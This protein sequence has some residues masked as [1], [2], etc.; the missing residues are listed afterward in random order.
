MNRETLMGI[1]RKILTPDYVPAFVPASIL[2]YFMGGSVGGFVGAYLG[3][4]YDRAVPRRVSPDSRKLVE[5]S[6]IISSD[7]TRRKAAL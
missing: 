1:G 3:S 6:D 7:A 4:E 5:V 2:G